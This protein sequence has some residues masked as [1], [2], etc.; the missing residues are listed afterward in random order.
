MEKEAKTI[1]SPD[2]VLGY[3]QAKALEKIA[4]DVISSSLTDIFPKEIITVLI[5]PWCHTM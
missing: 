1:H 4:L 5:G 3:E 2:V